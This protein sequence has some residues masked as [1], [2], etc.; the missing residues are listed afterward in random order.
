MNQSLTV[1][2]H[3]YHSTK[4]EILALK[5]VTMEQFQEYLL[6]KPFIV[7][8]DNNSLTYIITIPNLNTTQQHWVESLV[9]FTFSI[10]YQKGGD[11]AA[12]NA[13]S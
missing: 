4:Q 2:G 13:L 6:W 7:K 12:T 9:G 1:H 11:N 5:W 3:N 8:T 10:E